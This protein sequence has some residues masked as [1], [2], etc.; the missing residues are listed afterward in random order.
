MVQAVP[1][2]NNLSNDLV[3]KFFLLAQYHSPYPIYSIVHQPVSILFYK[4]IEFP[5][6]VNLI[7]LKA[8]MSCKNT[9]AGKKTRSKCANH[10]KAGF[11]TLTKEEIVDETLILQT[12]SIR[13][14]I[15][16]PSICVSK[17]ETISVEKVNA[18]Q[19]DQQTDQ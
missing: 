4:T 11:F 16:V 10:I 14:L 2:V 15:L 3:V 7:Q 19:W 8:K 1:V 6:A 18:C 5:S 13:W 12:V 9:L 17:Q